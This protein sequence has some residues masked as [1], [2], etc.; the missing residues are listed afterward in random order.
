VHI[1]ANLITN[2]TTLSI[3]DVAPLVEAAGLHSIFQGEHSHIPV[4]T[5]YPGPTGEVPDF[6]RRFPDLFV[7]M[8]GAA[9]VTTTL[10]IG[11]G[12]VLV[13]EHQPLR[14]AK[15]VAS[16]DVLSGGRLDFGVGYGWNAPEMVNNGVD[17]AQR[18]AVFR[19]DLRVIRALWDGDVVEHDGTYSSFTP[20]WSLPKPVQRGDLG[21]GPPVLLGAGATKRAFRDVL[22]LAD[23]WYPLSGPTIVE[24]AARLRDL[25]AAQSRT[26]EVSV[27]EM[28]GQMPGAPWYCDDAAARTQLFDT[29]RRYADGGID[30]VLVGVPVDGRGHLED[31]LAVLAE[32]AAACRGD[33]AIGAGA[34]S[35]RG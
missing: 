11:T 20:S 25:A 3:L 7:T 28:A 34:P 8:A 26:V 31:A 4:D 5:V 6:Y 30:R 32:L 14:L 33:D 18:G 2:D 27:V 35:Q 21:V 15:A 24:D 23:G 9:A 16:L 12:V 29:V 22:E 19:E 13:A 10:R 1:G 17:P